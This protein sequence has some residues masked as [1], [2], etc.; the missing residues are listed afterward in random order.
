MVG[1]TIVWVC[2]SQHSCDIFW[3]DVVLVSMERHFLVL[4]PGR[5]GMLVLIQQ[6]VCRNVNILRTMPIHILTINSIYF[7]NRTNTRI[8]RCCNVLADPSSS[9]SP[10]LTPYDS[11]GSKALTLNLTQIISIYSVTLCYML[12]Q[13]EH[14]KCSTCKNCIVHWEPSTSIYQLVLVLT[15]IPMCCTRPDQADAMQCCHQRP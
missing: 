12:M 3:A 11:Q 2:L 9:S 4:V 8:H 5:G 14:K 10:H 7:T 1:T 6:R 15:G 13:N